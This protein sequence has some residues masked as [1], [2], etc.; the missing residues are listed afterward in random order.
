MIFMQIH[1]KEDIQIENLE[2]DNYIRS[3][4]ERWKD[5]KT[6]GQT[7]GKIER[8]TDRQKD[9]KMDGR[10]ERRTYRRTDIYFDRYKTDGPTDQECFFVLY[11]HSITLKVVG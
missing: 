11:C 5:R 3:I 10:K 8:R 9:K 4:R 2:T 6:D 1:T 7:D